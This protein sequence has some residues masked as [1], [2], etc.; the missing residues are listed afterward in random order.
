M[1]RSLVRIQRRPHCLFVLICDYIGIY[2]KV[3]RLKINRIFGT[4]RFGLIFFALFLLFVAIATVTV[5]KHFLQNKTLVDAGY[6]SPQIY[7]YGGDSSFSSG[8]LIPIASTDQP[9][10]QIGG[11][12]ISGNAQIDIYKADSAILLDYLLHN[13]DG[14][15][16]K[17]AP[18]VSKLESL[19]TTN[20]NINTTSYEGSKVSLPLGETGIWYLK[21]KMGSVTADAF[22]LRSNFG[23]VAKEGDG[24][25][26]FW[27]QDFK[28]KRS[29]TEGSL[30]VLNLQDSQK[31]LS[32]TNFDSQGLAKA[33]ITQDADIAVAQIGSDMAIA[34]LNLK[35]LNTPSYKSFVEKTKNTNYFVFTDRPLYKPGD[36]VYFKAILR[37]D[38][39]ARYTIPSG[40]ALVKFES[41]YGPDQVLLE[42]SY[43]ISA[44]GTISG[45]YTIPADSKVGSYSLS[46]DTD[47]NGFIDWSESHRYSGVVYFDVQFYQ[48]PEFSVD[49]TTPKTELIAGDKSTFKVIGKYFSGQPMSGQKIK[50]KV[51]AAD[52]Y[53]YQYLQD[54][55]SM[56]QTLNNDYRYGFYG[57]QTVLEDT[58]VLDKNGEKE[59]TFDTKMDFNE[60]KS[61]VFSIE[62]TI[63]DNSITPSFARKNVLVYS[64]EYGIFRSDYTYG[65]KINT[66]LDIPVTLY[67]NKEKVSIGNVDLVGKVH[68]ENWVKYDDPNQKYPQYKKE[69]EDLPDIKGKTDNGGKGKLS[70]VPNKLGFYRITVQGKDDRG[71]LI[72]NIFYS[73]VTDQDQPAYT[74]RGGDEI[75]ISADKQKY[76]P[77]DLAKLSIYSKTADRDVFLSMERGRVNR[78]QIVRLN[79]T[80]ASVEM[81]IVD[82]DIP[83][84]YAKVSSFSSSVLDSNLVNLQVSTLS[85]RV[86]VGL[87]F[88]SSKY[89]PGDT[90]NVEVSTRDGLGNPVSSD[91][92]LWAVDK[93][94]F[95]L[96]DTRLGNIF[97]NF[98]NERGDT[99][100]ENHSLEGIVVLNAEGGGCFAEGTKVL[101]A[102]G[103]SKNIEEVKVGDY[104]LTKENENSE[105]LVKA[106]VIT[107]QKAKDPG[108]IIINGN[109]R[110][111]PDHIVWSNGVWKQAGSVQA[112]DSMT[113]VDGKSIYVS[114]IEWQRGRF[115]VFNLGVE[116]YNTYFADGYYVHNQKGDARSTFKDTAYWNPSIRTDSS[117]KAKV[118]FKLPDNLTTWTVAAV[119]ATSDTKV[120]QTTDEILVTKDVIVRPILPNILRIGD[121]VIISTLVQNSTDTEKSFNID[122]GFDSGEI[123]TQ[124]FKDAKIGSG[125]V[126]R[127]YWEVKPTKE[128]EKAK[129]DIKAVATTDSNIGDEIIQEIPVKAFGFYELSADVGEGNKTFKIELPQEV[130]KD[131]S[132]VTLSLSPTILGTLPTAMKYL[133]NY[134]YG[135]TEQITSSLV[136]ALIAKANSQIYADALK[137]KDIDDIIEKGIS[138]LELTQQGNGGWTWWFMGPSDPYITSYVVEYLAYAKKLGYKVD[139]STLDRAKSYLSS[140]SSYDYTQQKEISYNDEEWVVKNYGLMLLGDNKNVTKINL[141]NL[142]PDLLSLAVIT[143][144][145]LG[146]KNSET[147]GL[148]KLTSMAQQQGDAIFWESGDKKNFG[149]IDAST[150]FAIRA[151]IAAGGDRQTAVS[152]A[153]YLSRNRHY[154]YWS[155]TFATSQVI[156]AITDLSKN[157]DESTPNF[158]YS[159]TLDGKEIVNG[160]VSSVKDK[161]AD[162]EIDL[163]KLNQKGSELKVTQEG[164]GQIYSTLVTNAFHT[165]QKAPEVRNQLSIK[166]EYQNEKGSESALATGDSVLVKL[167]VTGPQALERY[168]VITDELPSGMVPINPMFKNEQYGENPMPAYFNSPDV[169]GMDVTQNGAVISLYKV[170]PGTH[171][172]TYRARVVSAGKFIVPPAYVSL[173]YAPEIYAR[174]AVQT[175]TI[176]SESKL[177]P[178]ALVG[179]IIKKYLVP[180]I[181]GAIGVVAS[182]FL[183]IKIV[184]K[185]TFKSLKNKITGIFKKKNDNIP[186]IMPPEVQ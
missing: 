61:Q 23:I 12:N 58:A 21:V 137:G 22:V 79:G 123:L 154:D 135:C 159:V 136:P 162:V 47:P 160:K 90:V 6:Q 77:N 110:V 157:G 132:T 144:Y 107:T 54:V 65:S 155:N 81:P 183:V 186:P 127:Y 98:W 120:G 93:A 60:G 106:K 13:K 185:G 71:N 59:I 45:E 66:N 67:P 130:S 179:V 46:V 170:E 11:Y 10:V 73:Y 34:P 75:T 68:R 64:G 112:G 115:D 41:G 50:Y 169:T 114:S 131:K 124:S 49:L 100:Q 80:K 163:T 138:K 76:N 180:I 40:S 94:I 20:H 82:T 9:I 74:E 182:I 176:A 97:S 91:V 181:I 72:S 3:V 84:M 172:Y 25:F 36:K 29:I 152:G 69:E 147:N 146:N 4:K 173:M 95:E 171:T 85:K 55:Q 119:A 35:Y 121:S 151:I 56:M 129:I 57:S 48:K 15:Q 125:N 63:D 2:T 113:G 42:K 174:S 118:S 102:N 101:M 153:R 108:Y 103:T 38:D 128:S 26:I 122:L 175:V 161:I 116:K 27:G 24:E 89:G 18:D 139:K 43:P 87:K 142:K 117:G 111:T 5:S 70:F 44:D 96:S 158:L 148:S 105:K 178:T 83:N 126:E 99:T 7:I 14:K 52:Y 32:Q 109:L 51:T 165:D 8:G 33:P 164:A 141:E 62:T 17:S 184:K 168:A 19:G 37:N 149:S 145:N 133:V 31:S 39:D 140:K 28:T 78:F 92:A 16:I 104:V 177:I 86:L 150:A 53:T 134:P 156:R 30:S 1:Q 166:R 88:D 143:N 167:T